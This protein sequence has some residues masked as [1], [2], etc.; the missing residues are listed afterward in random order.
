MPTKRLFSEWNKEELEAAF[1]LSRVF[2]HPRLDNWFE[3]A[4]TDEPT[5]VEHDLL[6]NLRQVLFE[7]ADMWN[8][9]EL[10]D[11][12]I[13]PLLAF[14]NYNT[15]EF[16]IFSDRPLS[17]IVGEYE[18]SGEPDA[19][20]AKGRYSPQIPYFCFHEYKK[21]REPKG[22]P[23][24]QAL[25]AML[26]ARDATQRRHPVYGMYVVGEHWYFMVLEEET[27]C[28]SKS[29]AADDDDIFAIFKI[30]KALKAILIEIAKQ[31]A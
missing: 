29:F 28:I 24:A 3:Q 14:V 2:Q 6:S 18:L 31:D 27:Y 16:K 4:A 12:L 19:V 7:N 13:G 11:Y 30:L 17:G 22:D 8:E 20:I 9:T 15:P 5:A 1:G 25:A 21:A 10:R 26:V 23:A